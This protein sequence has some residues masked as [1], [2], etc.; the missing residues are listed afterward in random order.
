MVSERPIQGE[1]LEIPEPEFTEESTNPIY[2]NNIRIST[3]PNEAVFDFFYMNAEP[4]FK[5]KPKVRHQ[6]KC[7]LILSLPLAGQLLTLLKQHVQPVE[8]TGG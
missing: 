1:V 5:E 4:A 6:H 8:V 7:R 3:T 2:C